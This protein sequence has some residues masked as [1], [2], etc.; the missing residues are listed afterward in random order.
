MLQMRAIGSESS[1]W[2]G[3]EG[4]DPPG[5]ERLEKSW[6]EGRHGHLAGPAGSGDNSMT[7]VEVTLFPRDGGRVSSSGK[8]G[9]A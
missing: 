6:A 9:S 7:C 8:T 4:E 2:R 3:L 1:R 5:P